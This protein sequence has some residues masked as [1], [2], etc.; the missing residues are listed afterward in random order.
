MQ[1]ERIIMRN[2]K[3]AVARLHNKVTFGREDNTGK[4]NP[5]TGKAIKGFEPL[6]TVHCGTYSISTNQAI[7]L[8]GSTVTDNVVLVVRHNKELT[9]VKKYPQAQYNGNIYRVDGWSIDDE[10]LAYD[11]VTLHKIDSHR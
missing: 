8:A 1:A 7:S 3:Y 10:L 4:I 11:T 6:V 5:N 9:N 2:N